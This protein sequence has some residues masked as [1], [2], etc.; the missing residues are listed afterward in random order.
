MT[1]IKYLR[2]VCNQGKFQERILGVLDFI[3]VN[4]RVQKGAE[5]VF[6]V[7]IIIRNKVNNTN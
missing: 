6:G 5:Y 2:R 1:L 7:D 4:G 3:L